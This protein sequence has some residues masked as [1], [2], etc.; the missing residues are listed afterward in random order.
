MATAT[1]VA[2][3][4][5][6]DGDGGRSGGEGDD[7]DDD[8]DNNDDN[9]D[10]DNDDRDNSNDHDNNNNGDEDCFRLVVALVW[11][12]AAAQGRGPVPLSLFFV[13]SFAT[14]K[15]QEKF[16]PRVPPRSRL[17]T[18][19]SPP[20]SADLRLVVVSIDKTADT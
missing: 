13:A 2:G 10:K 19:P 20:A 3:D 12:G 7:V 14:P 11:L 5:E 16:S 6:G 9:D 1:W 4:E 18:L 8:K 15:R 17:I